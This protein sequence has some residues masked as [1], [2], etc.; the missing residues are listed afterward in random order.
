M[1]E[2]VK[3]VLLTAARESW[4]F[5]KSA[6]FL[7]NFGI[8]LVLAFLGIFVIKIWLSYYTNHGQALKVPD[9]IQM[10][11]DDANQ[12]AKEN[13]FELVVSDSV[14]LLNQAPHRILVQ[15]P[16]ADFKVKEHRKI[17]VT[18]TKN[19]PDLVKIPNL[20]AGNDDYKQY[21]RKLERIGVGA[22]I[23]DRK[24]SIKLEKN[25]ILEIKYDGET[26]TEKVGEGFQVPMG[27]TLEFVV[28][29]RGGGLVEVPNLI[30]K[31]YDAAKFLIKNYGLKVGNATVGSKVKD[32]D[33]AYVSRQNP[34]YRPG[35]K[36]DI[37]AT[38][39]VEIVGSLPKNC[40]GGDDYNNDSQ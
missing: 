8:F 29:D 17:Y 26:I 10:D 30:C 1:L 2:K 40:T 34:A 33:K 18:V 32:P 31:S 39:D 20:L 15:D 16:P 28:T 21:S 22:K 23:V 13:T 5:L 9:F 4:H 36:M 14:F 3:N 11:F 6:I 19:I 7:K 12:L 27:S 24:Y 35:A 38:I 37:G 25:T